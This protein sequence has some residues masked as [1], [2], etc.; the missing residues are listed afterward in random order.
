M[1]KQYIIPADVRETMIVLASMKDDLED[2]FSCELDDLLPEYK[3]DL[4]AWTEGGPEPDWD[5]YRAIV[6]ELCEENGYPLLFD[7]IPSINLDAAKELPEGS[8][9]P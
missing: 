4:K 6:N 1:D 7:K 5:Y 9:A 8:F 2:T 3:T